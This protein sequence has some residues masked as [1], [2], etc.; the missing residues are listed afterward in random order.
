MNNLKSGY[1]TLKKNTIRLLTLIVITQIFLSSIFLITNGYGDPSEI[2]V[3]FGD[4]PVIDGIIDGTTGE[5]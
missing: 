3:G 2:K 5:W 4:A 1:R